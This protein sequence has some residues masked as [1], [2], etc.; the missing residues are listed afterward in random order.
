MQAG[1]SAALLTE[2]GIVAVEAAIVAT[3]VTALVGGMWGFKV[4]RK[5]F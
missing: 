2:I 4:L 1:A 5:Q 3:A